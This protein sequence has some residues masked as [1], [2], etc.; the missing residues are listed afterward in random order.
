MIRK[1]NSS[2][3]FT[4]TLLSDKVVDAFTIDN[5]HFVKASLFTNNNLGT[6]VKLVHKEEPYFFI[7]YKKTYNSSGNKGFY[8]KKPLYYFNIKGELKRVSNRKAFIH[9]FSPHEKE[10]RQ[11]LNGHKI[12]FQNATQSE[13]E[14]LVK[15]SKK[16]IEEANE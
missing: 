4:H 10:I 13:L 16:F 12:D 15:F 3:I 5:Q 6:Y 11:Y 2:G 14:M 9:L 7:K 8:F 1:I